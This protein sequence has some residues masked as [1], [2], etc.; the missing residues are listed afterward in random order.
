MCNFYLLIFFFIRFYNIFIKSL[1]LWGLI[2]FPSFSAC[3]L[4]IGHFFSSLF[5]D[6]L[7]PSFSAIYLS[8]PPTLTSL[9]QNPH[10]F[11]NV[12]LISKHLEVGQ[13]LKVQFLIKKLQCALNYCSLLCPLGWLPAWIG[14]RRVM[15]VEGFGS[16]VRRER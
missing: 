9:L 2:L 7:S 11:K 3:F 13:D 10:P 5:P 14:L 12:L 16:S 4:M 15:A 6:C 8:L 1:N